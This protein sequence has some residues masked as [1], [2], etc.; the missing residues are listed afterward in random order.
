MRLRLFP[1]GAIA[2]ILLVSWQ[3]AALRAAGASASAVK[4]SG[5]IAYKGTTAALRYAAV[6]KG[7]DAIDE[8]KIIRRLVLSPTD[9]GSKLAACATM[10]CVDS[11]LADGVEVDFDAG[12]RLNY[13]LVLKG[14]LIQYSGT[15]DPAA[16]TG[17]SGGDGIAGRLTIDDTA[18]GGPKIDAAFDAPLLRRFDRA[19]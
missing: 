2:A 1:L 7:P 3:D 5:T 8:K 6:V 4:T 18:A 13:W 10:A 11:A 9:V 19:R 16:F 17:K 12:P 14:Q 15:A